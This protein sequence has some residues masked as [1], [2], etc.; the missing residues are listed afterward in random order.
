VLA[1]V[2][3]LLGDDG[4]AASTRTAVDMPRAPRRT[5]ATSVSTDESDDDAHVVTHTPPT[6]KQRA[7]Q[8]SHNARTT[9]SSSSSSGKPKSDVLP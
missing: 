9:S 7:P 8:S 6:L 2:R 4:P 1:L 3:S 5:D